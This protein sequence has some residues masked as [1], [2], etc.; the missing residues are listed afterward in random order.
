MLVVDQFEEIFRYRQ[1]NPDEADSFL[2]LLLRSASE[3]LPI[4]AVITMRSAFLGHCV[5]FHGLPEAINAGLYLTPRLAT[6]QIKPV[7]VSPLTLVGGTIDPVLANCM[8]NA[9]TGDDELPILQH[10]LLCLG[11]RAR[12]L[13]RTEIDADDFKAICAIAP[14]QGR[15]SRGR[16]RASARPDAFQCHRQPCRRYP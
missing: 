16:R 4:Y 9:L 15:H 2:T 1:K 6:E 7:I 14:G 3:A 8:L 11:Q 5:A 10:A 12:S 13:G